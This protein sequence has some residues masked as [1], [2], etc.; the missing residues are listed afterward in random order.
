MP[1]DSEAAPGVARLVAVQDKVSEANQERL[2]RDC[3][4]A[5]EIFSQIVELFDSSARSGWRQ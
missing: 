3:R 4:V 5:E 2:R 1:E